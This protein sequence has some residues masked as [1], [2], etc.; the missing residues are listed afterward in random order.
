MACIGAIYGWANQ[1][2]LVN[3]KKAEENSVNRTKCFQEMMVKEK[4]RIQK[5]VTLINLRVNTIKKDVEDAGDLVDTRLTDE[6]KL[7]NQFTTF[8]SPGTQLKVNGM[9][10]LDYLKDIE[11]D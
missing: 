6:L 5:A 4:V 1:E 11:E 2:E 3:E 9:L 7:L 10:V 8:I